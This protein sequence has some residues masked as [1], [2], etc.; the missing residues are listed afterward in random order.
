[1]TK[2]ML[3]DLENRS[4][5]ARGAVRLAPSTQTHARPEVDKVIVFKD[6]FTM[7]LRFPL[8]PTVVDIFQLYKVYTHQMTPNS[9]V[10]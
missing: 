8:D 6:F 5:I 1:M 9:F 2:N 10:W 4:V 3:K 7:G